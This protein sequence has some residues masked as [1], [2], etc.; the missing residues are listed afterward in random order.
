[1]RVTLNGSDLDLLKT[2]LRLANPD[3]SPSQRIEAAAKGL[4]YTTY[5]GLRAALMER[6]VEVEANEKLYCELLEIDRRV[7]SRFAVRPLG[8]ALAKIELSRALK[9]HENLTERG[10]DSVWLGGSDEL[11]L[12]FA[13][14][15]RLLKVRRAETFSSDWAADQFELAWFYLS[16]QSRTKNINRRTGSYGLKHR[17]EGLNRKYGLF[18]P[19]GNYVSNGMLI[20]AACSLGFS[21]K[22]MGYNSYNAW[23]NISMRTVKATIGRSGSNPTFQRSSDA[24]REIYGDLNARIAA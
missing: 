19:L 6:A 14:R 21:V 16:R 24:I 7:D 1:M 8:R 13:D 11:A 17:A 3:L 9:E 10:F 23:L 22:S 12:P 15:V 5:A 2:H 18:E 20:A 4:G